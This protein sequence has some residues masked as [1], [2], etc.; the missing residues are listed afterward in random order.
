MSKHKSIKALI[1][2]L[3][4]LTIYN[5]EQIISTEHKLETE[6]VPLLKQHSLKQTLYQE[7]LSKAK[8][9]NILATS[10][11]MQSTHAKLATSIQI[12]NVQRELNALVL[13]L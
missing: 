8:E 11:V 6:I 1:R 5:A 9:L 10:S 13:Q 12:E 3:T 4:T 7:I 2:K